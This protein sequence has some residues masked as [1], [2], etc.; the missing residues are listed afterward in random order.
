MENGAA[1]LSYIKAAVKEIAEA[2]DG[3]K[4][5]MTKSTVPVGTNDMLAKLVSALLP[6]F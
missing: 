4:I 6:S 1:D 2:M 5:I 3:Y